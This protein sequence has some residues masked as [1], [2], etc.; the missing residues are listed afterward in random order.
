MTRPFL[1]AELDVDVKS[2]EGWASLRTYTHLIS[3]VGNIGCAATTRTYGMTTVTYN[4]ALKSPLA[5]I[6]LFL[7][8]KIAGRGMSASNVP[9]RM[10]QV[11][12]R[13]GICHR[14]KQLETN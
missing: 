7:A 6:E 3:S 9:T 11:L 4:A 2:D 1:Q 10:R 13:M 14:A 12:S 8:R 5:I